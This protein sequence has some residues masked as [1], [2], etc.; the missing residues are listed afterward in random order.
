M[1][2]Q[3]EMVEVMEDGLVKGVE[4]LIDKGLIQEIV[5]ITIDTIDKNVRGLIETGAIAAI[6]AAVIENILMAGII[7]AIKELNTSPKEATYCEVQT[8]LINLLRK[9]YCGIIPKDTEQTIRK[10]N[11]INKLGILMQKVIEL[12]NLEAFILYM[13]AYVKS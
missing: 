8:I 9:K 11:D 10:I 13:N 5:Q 12:D 2:L 3:H 4:K 7:K 1:G 6:G